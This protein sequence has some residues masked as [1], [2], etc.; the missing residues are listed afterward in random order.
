MVELSVAPIVFPLENDTSKG[1]GHGT[2]T[3]NGDKL[4][5]SSSI[6]K[7]EYTYKIKGTSMTVTHKLEAYVLPSTTYTRVSDSTINQYMNYK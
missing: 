3:I 5:L 4:I 6:G 7:T 1:T 2:Y